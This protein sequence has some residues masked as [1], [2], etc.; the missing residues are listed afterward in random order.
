MPEP[1]QSWAKIGTFKAHKLQTGNKSS[2]G[3]RTILILCDNPYKDDKCPYN[4][5]INPER[6]E[7]YESVL[8]YTLDDLGSLLPENFT[9]YLACPGIFPKGSSPQFESLKIMR[10]LKPNVVLISGF[11]IVK[12]LISS[13]Y[14]KYYGYLRPF[15]FEAENSSQKLLTYETTMAYTVP[16]TGW[17][18]PDPPIK[19]ENGGGYV[20]L[21]GQFIHHLQS[22]LLGKN[23]STLK[24]KDHINL[25]SMEIQNNSLVIP[26][27]KAFTYVD[28]LIKFKRFMKILKQ[29]SYKDIMCF[30]TEGANL[31]RVKNK[32]LTM[33]ILIKRYRKKE[34]IYFIPFAHKETPFTPKELLYIKKE[35][36][37]WFETGQSAYIVMHGSKYDLTQTYSQFGVR[38]F[39]HEVWDTMA[40]EFI[41]DEN[42][43]F[44]NQIGVSEPYSLV[45][46]E[47]RY[48]FERPDMTMG[49]KDRANMSNI[50]LLDIVKYGSYDVIGPYEIHIQQ[51]REGKR[52]GYNN[53]VKLVVD[54]LGRTLK[55]IACMEFAGMPVNR[56]RLT[57]LI[58]PDSDMNSQI[59]SLMSKFK[60]SKA[61]KQINHELLEER[62]FQ[63][64]G[65]FGGNK[66]QFIFDMGTT[67][68]KHR[69]FFDKLKLEPID[70]GVKGD[71]LL[72]SDFKETYKNVPEVASFMQ[73]EK[74]KKIKSGFI[75]NLYERLL[76]EPDA[77]ADGRIR[78]TY[79]FLTVLT[80]RLSSYNPNL[81]NQPS[82]GA[83]APIVKSVWEVQDPSEYGNA[84]VIL[85]KADYRAHEA[86]GLGIVGKDRVIQ[87]VFQKADAVL[88]E[89]RLVQANKLND[90][91]PRFNRESDIHLLNVEFFFNKVVTKDDPLRYAV[92]SIVFGVIYGKQAYALG[93]DLLAGVKQTVENLEESLHKLRIDSKTAKT[94][95]DRI[96]IRKKIAYQSYVLEQSKR[97]LQHKT[98]KDFKNEAQSLIDKLF[99]TWE[100]A[101]NWIRE[102][103]RLGQRELTVFNPLGMPRHLYAYLHMSR[104]VQSAMDRRGPNSIIQG[105]A[106]QAGTISSY[107]IGQEVWN[108]FVSKGIDIRFRQVNTV[109][110]S[111]VNECQWEAIPVGI[112][113]IEHGMTTL[114]MQHIQNMYGFNMTIPFNI[115]LSLGFSENTLI[116][117]NNQRFDTMANMITELAEKRKDISR[118]QLKN[119]LHNLGC[120]AKV[121]HH[122]IKK[123]STMTLKGDTDWYEKNMW[124]IG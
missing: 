105:F 118:R 19:G 79:N 38:W 109:H 73:L 68:H 110:D 21:I 78:A 119:C 53:Y 59:D 103:H 17:T 10:K 102:T 71:P 34:H 94:A 74:L 75:D 9:I 49:K 72:N 35:L 1:Q 5:V 51:R 89:V 100:E 32:L 114:T 120:I 45:S 14:A 83:L 37:I 6:L 81:Q 60:K 117:W 88:N 2:K 27:N 116:D 13:G 123:N 108:T 23:Y 77:M 101:G 12:N 26:E 121:R 39:N 57:E 63:K 95:K 55:V 48:G 41:L 20:N 106:S 65:L 96:V 30:D 92:K 90:L 86:R 80:G 91:M 52:R 124:G 107:C 11:S 8:S 67:D 40:G 70:Y 33:Q 31:N 29:F 46:I 61:V 58:S 112:Y 76:S 24:I 111:L 47:N 50:S 104:G 28:T 43:K 36:R 113:L 87:S 16:V 25:D 22:A 122:E 66:E 62:G 4:R 7:T 18:N 54:L 69:L 44:L 64:T 99:E 82:R 42:L 84:S 85:L 3:H 15:K 97:D 98:D 93:Q 56:N 115:D